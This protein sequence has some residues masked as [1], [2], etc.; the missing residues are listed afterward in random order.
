MRELGVD[1]R[2]ERFDASYTLPRAFALEP[3]AATL[4]TVTNDFWRRV[5]VYATEPTKGGLA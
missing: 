3:P 1:T 4:F 5:D 2:N